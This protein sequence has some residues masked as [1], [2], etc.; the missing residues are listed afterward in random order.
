MSGNAAMSSNAAMTGNAATSGDAAMAGN[1]AMT[2][3]I[4]AYEPDQRLISLIDTLATE[5]P[6][7]ELVLVDDGSGPSY[8]SVFDAAQVLGAQ[9]L[10]HEH[11]RGKGAALKTGF[12]YIRRMHPGRDVVCVDC[13][14]QHRPDDIKRVSN[15]LVAH[16]TGPVLGVRSFSGNIPLRSRLGNAITKLVF[17][18]ASGLSLSDTQTGL[19]GYPAAFL[20]WLGE[21]RGDRFEYELEALLA[22][23]RDGQAISQ[24]PIETVYLDNN[25]S[26][27]FR[28]L[29][30]SARVYWP[31]LRFAGSSLTSFAIDLTVFLGLASFLGLWQ[32]VL[33][34]RI[35][36]AGSNYALNR[37]VVFDSHTSTRRS[38][39]RY[40]VLAAALLAA[41]YLL[42][43]LLTG[44]G[45]S[46]LA[47]KL[48]TEA[49]LVATSFRLQQRFV[50]SSED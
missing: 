25:S 43:R 37:S 32:A 6:G 45:V 47:A 8:R 27:H 17:R 1:A 12:N 33:G 28:P 31:F 18:A 5:L 11:N 9:P 13:D 21:V 23:Q 44:A 26:S 2:I 4:P 39:P 40:A 3:L 30:D 14:G 46:L 10:S 19:R 22:G 42:L 49:A 29:V 35:I 50:F 34:A 36:S 20:P 24:V 15:E 16:R 48:P 7:Y 38:L 41:N